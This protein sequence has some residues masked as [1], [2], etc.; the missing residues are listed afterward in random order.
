MGISLETPKNWAEFSLDLMRVSLPLLLLLALG[1]ST[2]AGS[3][4]DKPH[5]A[6][7]DEPFM[8]M[9]AITSCATEH[10]ATHHAW[11][12]TTQQ[13]RAQL[14]RTATATAIAPISSLPASVRS[15]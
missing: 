11:P 5:C 9:L 3:K 6:F 14:Q 12:S 15:S 7:S 1:L 2:F 8:T 4:T 10:F 13:L